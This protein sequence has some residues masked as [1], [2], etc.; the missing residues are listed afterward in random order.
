MIYN[1]SEALFRYVTAQIHGP[2]SF[3]LKLQQ[4]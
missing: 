1:C 4:G 2:F 3:N